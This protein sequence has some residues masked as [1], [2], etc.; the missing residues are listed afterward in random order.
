MALN[1]DFYST[2]NNLFQKATGGTSTQVTDY[3]SYIDAGKSID[4]VN[5]TELQN[6]FINALMDRIALVVNTARN[7]EGAYSELTRGSIGFG[8]TIELIIQGFYDAQPAA[9]ANLTDGQ[10]V[11]QYE[12]FKPK[13]DVDYF[14]DSNAYTIPITIQRDQLKKAF[15]NPAEMESLI[16]GIMMYVMNSNEARREQARIGL[17]ANLIAIDTNTTPATDTNTPSQYYKLC[18][19]YNDIAGTQLTQDNCLYNEEFVRFAVSTINKVVGKTTKISESYN[20]NG[21][22]TFTRPQDRHLFINSALA[23]ANGTYVFP[24]AFNNSDEINLHDYIDVPYWQ[25][26]KTPL[27]VT[28]KDLEGE[29]QT[30]PPVI[31]VMCDKF[32]IGEYVRKQD[33][34]T[35]PFNARGEYWDNYLN[36]E[37]KYVT[38]NSANSIVFTLE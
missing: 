35:T 38:C 8:N 29:T 21:I 17:V 37:L 4:G 13:V 20:S 2:M 1:N 3:T 24:N 16:S 18:T 23:S 6:N 36:V 5:G 31:A 11:D 7:Y 30:S 10:S 14:I 25:D 19:L 34:F 32:A 15:E 9:F 33:M 28:Y 27:T 22:K 12:I 26:E